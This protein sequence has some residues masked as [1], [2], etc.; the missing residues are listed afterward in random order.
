MESIDAMAVGENAI[1]Q[2]MCM[3]LDLAP[4]TSRR[5]FILGGRDVE[6]IALPMLDRVS[7]VL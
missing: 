4:Y 5:F 6:R 1:K 3:I 7:R 2:C